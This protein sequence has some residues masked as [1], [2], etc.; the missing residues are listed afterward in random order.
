MSFLKQLLARSGYFGLFSKIKKGSGTSFWCTFSA[1]FF[2]KNVSLILCLCTKLH[3]H[4]FFP[5][6]DTKQNVIYFRSSSKAMIDREKKK[7]R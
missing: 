7:G 3:C 2:H 6:Q 4:T 1:Y 5:S